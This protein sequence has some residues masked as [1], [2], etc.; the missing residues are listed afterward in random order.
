MA[1]SVVWL[2]PP[3]VVRSVQAFGNHSIEVQLGMGRV[4]VHLDMLHVHRLCDPCMQ[5]ARSA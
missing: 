3:L 4:V 2:F 1:I 5:H